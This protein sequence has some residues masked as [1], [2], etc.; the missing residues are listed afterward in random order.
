MAVVAETPIYSFKKKKKTIL[1][2]N[3]RLQLHRCM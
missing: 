3:E 2:D 1:E